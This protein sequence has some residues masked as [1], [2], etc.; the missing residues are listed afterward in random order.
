MQRR[1]LGDDR[2]A[3]AGAVGPRVLAAGERLEQALALGGG[4]AG[5]VVLDAHHQPAVVALE[6]DADAA[7]VRAAV[8]GGVVE[9]VVDD[10][11]QAALP[12]VD[13][14]L[15]DVAR[16]LVADARVALA[17]AV[18]G[19]VEDV[20]ELDRLARQAVGGL[21]ARQ[22]LQALEQVDHAVLLGGHVG[23][24]RVALLGREA[25]GCA[26]AC[27]GSRASRS[28]AC[29][30][31]GRRRRRSGGSPRARARWR[32]STRRGARASR[33]ARPRAG[34]PPPGPRRAAAS[35][36]PRAPLTRAAPAAQARERPDR[37]RGEAPGRERG[38]RERGE[39]EQQ[40]EPAD[41]ADALLDGRER[42]QH[43][44]P[45]AAGERERDRQRAPRRP[46]DVDRL[47]A[48]VGRARRRGVSGTS[49]ACSVTSLP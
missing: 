18:D 21:A 23:H 4:D 43:L 46:G 30:A 7:A 44:E 25:R 8:Q 1:L 15:V 2:E 33:S 36:G 13:R 47:E 19:G 38:Q 14:A 11:P 41:R 10:Q 16:Q 27:R 12:A 6:P 49:P 34:A 45:R 31:R 9:Q 5:A 39:A 37:D 40:H 24:Q 20:A 28:A 22:R 17:R 3:E 48:V 26:R 32:R 42:A 35:R 29:A